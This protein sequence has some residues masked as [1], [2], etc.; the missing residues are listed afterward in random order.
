MIHVTKTFLPPQEEYIQQLNRAWERHWITNNG[1]LVQ[2]LEEKLRAT[3]NLQ[4]L[5]FCNNGTIVLQMALKALNITKAVITT[6]FSYVATTNTILWENASPVFVDIDPHTCCINAD[7]IEAAITPDT[8]AILATHVYGLPCDVE[9]IE[10]I[11]KKHGLFVIYDAAH[12]FGATYNGRSLLSYGDIS[13][14]SFH[15]TKV[16]HTVEGGSISVNTPDEELRERIYFYRQFGHLNDDYR[17]VGINGKNSEFHAAMGLT[18]LPHFDYI[19]AKRKAIVECYAAHLDANIATINYNI[20]NYSFNY[21]YFPVFF[22]NELELLQVKNALE[23]EKI[24]TRRYFYPA[25][26]QLPF[27][28]KNEDC[29]V[30]TQKSATV[31][32]L[33]LYADLP[34]EDVIRISNLINQNLL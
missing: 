13:T 5:L 33:P 8:Q 12:T 25:L 9:K 21:A 6:P 30:A 23:Q 29:P 20:P 19:I 31:L 28:D 34:L 16:F 1:V 10:F 22:K 26:H 18:V 4:H 11:A 2:E 17:S 24:F 32:C 27:L 7:L 14:C 15:A 3:L